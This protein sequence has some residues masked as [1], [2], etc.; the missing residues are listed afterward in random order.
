M[1]ELNEHPYAHIIWNKLLNV[2]GNKHG[3]AGLMGNLQAESGLYPDRVQGDVPYSS[4]S[5]EYTAKVDNGQ[6]SENDFVNNGINGGGYGLAQWTYYTRKQKLY[7]MWKS[8]GYT[9]IGS[10]DLACDFLLWEL[11]NSFSGVFNTLKNATSIREASD[12]VLHDFESPADQSESVEE[13]RAS[14]GTEIY[15]TF[16]GSSVTPDNPD[17]PTTSTKRKLSKLLLFAVATDL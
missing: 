9:S 13:L 6:I 16:S 14:M 3:V 1:A 5:Q 15:N 10:V 7:D 12:K 17:T 11:E 4:F 8:G 2:I